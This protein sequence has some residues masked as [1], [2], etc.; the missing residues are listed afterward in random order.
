[1]TLALGDRKGPPL[2]ESLESTIDMVKVPPS[3]GSLFRIR[4]VAAGGGRL[5][6][7]VI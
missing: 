5:S 3:N 2:I 7:Q 1:M 6:P 4:L